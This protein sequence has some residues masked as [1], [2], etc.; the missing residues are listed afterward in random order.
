MYSIFSISLPRH[1]N[2][3]MGLLESTKLE[4]FF[5]L[6]VGMSVLSF[7]ES[8]IVPEFQEKLIALSKMG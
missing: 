8:G 2:N 1:D 6:N 4:I 3:T 5:G 7:K